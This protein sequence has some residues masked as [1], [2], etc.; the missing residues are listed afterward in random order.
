MTT[1]WEGR[2]ICRKMEGEASSHCSQEAC[3]ADRPLLRPQQQVT[4]LTHS[5]K[6]KKLLMCLNMHSTSISLN[7]Q[8][9]LI[10]PHWSVWN[11]L[12]QGHKVNRFSLTLGTLKQRE[13]TLL[14]QSDLNIDSFFY[15]KCICYVL[16]KC[17]Q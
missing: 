12:P 11:K 17:N 4:Y 3:W 7:I 6:N 10:Q 14:F 13:V 2:E 8:Q 1:I 9:H 16:Y 15:A 5:T